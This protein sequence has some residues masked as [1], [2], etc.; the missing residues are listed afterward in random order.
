MHP[1]RRAA[2]VSGVRRV[3]YWLLAAVAIALVLL[4]LRFGPPL[5]VLLRDQVALEQALAQLGWLGPA[6]LVLINVLQ[7]VVAPIP[8]YVMQAAAGYLYGPLWGGVWGSLGLVLGAMLA[9]ALARA[10]GR[11][12]AE[13]FVGP[14]RLAHWESTTHSTNTFLWFVLLAAPTGDLPYFMAGLSSVSFW[15]I[16]ALTLLIRVPSTFVV[17]ALGAGAWSMPGWQL[18]LLAAALVALLALATHHRQRLVALL[19]RIIQRRL[20]EQES[21]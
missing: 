14:E 9:M 17:A 4:A 16:L 11:P 18:T 7:I 5:W 1:S 3:Q 2:L 13:H 19:D 8:G 20:P 21:L 10:F 15:K 6:A 12:L